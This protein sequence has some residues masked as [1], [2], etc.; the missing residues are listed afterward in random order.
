M[1]H[2]QFIRNQSR[3]SGEDRAILASLYCIKI[4]DKRL[5]D[6]PKAVIDAYEKNF[7]DQSAN[8]SCENGLVIPKATK[9]MDGIGMVSIDQNERVPIE[10]SGLEDGLHTGEDTLKLLEYIS[11]CLQGENAFYQQVSYATFVKRHLF[12]IQFVGYKLT[13]L[14]TFIGEDNLQGADLLL[15]LGLLN[16]QD[17]VMQQLI[18]EHNGLISVVREDTMHNYCLRYAFAL[19]CQQANGR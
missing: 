2:I 19:P 5:P 4:N 15:H 8:M 11:I 16:T 13:L 7:E 1:I 6:T 18:A 10:S 14:T 3:V 17:R 12:D 9:L